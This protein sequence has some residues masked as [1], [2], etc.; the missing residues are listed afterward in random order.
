MHTNFFKRTSILIIGILILSACNLPGE[1]AT[2]EFIP[3]TEP[4]ATATSEPT[5]TFT[6]AIPTDTPTETPTE[7]PTLKPSATFTPVPPMAT[8]VRESNC[9]IGPGGMYD[10]VATYQPGQVLEVIGKDLGNGY[11]FVKNP[12]KPEEQCYLLEQ[13]LTI[14]GDITVLPQF[15]PRPSPTA[16]PYFNVNFKKFDT[17][18]GQDY[19]IFVVENVGSVAF[20]SMYIKVTDKKVNKFVEQALNAFDLRVGCVLAKN[21]AP[22]E[23]GATGYVNSPPFSWNARADKLTAVIYLCTEKDL[24]G[25]CV[26]QI[27]E[28]KE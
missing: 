11:L 15:T 3:P 14:T 2:A 12:E 26:T 20:R 17:C 28:V 18:N 10:L 8:V 5:N 27:L 19:A 9:R 1:T 22:L 21:I 16:A 4:Q 23:R 6:P 7:T 13:N 25:T 24:K